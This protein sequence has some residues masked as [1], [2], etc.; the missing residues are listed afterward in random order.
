M[1]GRDVLRGHRWRRV[2]AG[3]GAA[4]GGWEGCGMARVML[5]TGAAC[6]PASGVRG[7][8]GSGGSA[9][10]QGARRRWRCEAWR[11]A[12]GGLYAAAL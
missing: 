8:Q 11:S 4:Q 10:Q 3:T 2:G 12:H 9:Q 5:G 1:A 7:R 6:V